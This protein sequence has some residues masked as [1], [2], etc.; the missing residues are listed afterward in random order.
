LPSAWA[1]HLIADALLRRQTKKAPEIIFRAPFSILERGD[2]VN[3]QHSTLNT[4]QLS[5]FNI[6]E[7]TQPILGA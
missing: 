5:T 1:F 6:E 4:W 7:F 3:T 2:A